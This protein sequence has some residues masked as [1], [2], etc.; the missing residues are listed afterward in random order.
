MQMRG[1]VAQP[2]LRFSGPTNDMSS[3]LHFSFPS[4]LKENLINCGLI[5][6]IDRSGTGNPC[7]E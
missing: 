1:T 2:D 6:R 4:R 3:I 5:R 7:V